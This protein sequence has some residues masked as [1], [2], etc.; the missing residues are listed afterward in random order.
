M[1][2]L[3]NALVGGQA[4]ARIGIGCLAER[5]LVVTGIAG[6]GSLAGIG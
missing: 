6:T 3:V 1:C 4:G 2:S 5:T